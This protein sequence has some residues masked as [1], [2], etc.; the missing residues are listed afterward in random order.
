MEGFNAIRIKI[1]TDGQLYKIQLEMDSG[2]EYNH[3][4]YVLLII[5]I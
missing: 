3:L 2:F 5:N 1:K 4:A